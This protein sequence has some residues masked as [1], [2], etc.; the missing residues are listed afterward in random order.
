MA[1][2]RRFA[3]CN[4]QFQNFPFIEACKH[5]RSLGYEGIEIAPFTLAE[6]PAK[7]THEERA[8]FKRIIEGEGLEYVGLHWLLAA[9]PGLHVT[10]PD[11]NIRKRSW[12]HVHSLI[13]LSFD[14]AGPG[15]NK[16]VLVFGSPKQ[17]QTNGAIPVREAV[18]IFTHE[19]AHA[20]AHAETSGVTI[21]VEAL[22]KNQ[23]D[24]INI[25]AEAVAIVRQIG[26]PAVQTMFDTHNA[27]DEQ[28][29]IPELLR[30]YGQYIRHVHVNEIDGSEPGYRDYDF[31]PVLH[32]LNELEY[33]G[34]V[35]VE[36][37]DFSRH[38]VEIASRAIEHLRAQRPRTR[39]TRQ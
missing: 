39:A 16:G 31:A 11:E 4:E 2:S 15:D 24:V 14:L 12:E 3:I 37:L 27:V 13:D 33:P 10:S 22:P 34:W 38:P 17:R 32:A 8:E 18:D 7:L 29:P 6:D 26:S 19:L 9:P 36:A 1:S 35:S 5:I 30:R 25:L 21:L 20:A 28:D 23:C